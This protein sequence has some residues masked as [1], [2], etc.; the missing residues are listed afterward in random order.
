MQLVSARISEKSQHRRILRQYMTE[1]VQF[2]EISIGYKRFTII[3]CKFFLL[4]VVFF[5]KGCYNVDKIRHGTTCRNG[6][7]V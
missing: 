1:I 4:V 7:K 5:E 6:G 3:F 2:G